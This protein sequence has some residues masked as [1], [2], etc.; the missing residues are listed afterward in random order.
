M[1]MDMKDYQTVHLDTS[2]GTA[3]S[4]KG[5]GCTWTWETIQHYTY[6]QEKE[7]LVVRKDMDVHGHERLSNSTLRYK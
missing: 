3:C 4:K 7:Q 2:K 6:I 5:Y 1:Y